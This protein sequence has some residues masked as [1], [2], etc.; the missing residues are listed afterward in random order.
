MLFRI[1]TINYKRILLSMGEPFRDSSIEEPFELLDFHTNEI[2]LAGALG[3][4]ADPVLL[5]VH[6]VD[7]DHLERLKFRI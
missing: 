5:A 6:D 7:P 2:L 4:L 3:L 1:N